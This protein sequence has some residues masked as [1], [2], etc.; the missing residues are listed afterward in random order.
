M[1]AAAGCQAVTFLG[2]VTLKTKAH[3][4]LLAQLPLAASS[5][6]KSGLGGRTAFLGVLVILR[7]ASGYLW[8]QWWLEG[9]LEQDGSVSPLSLVWAIPCVL[10]LGLCAPWEP[11]PLPWNCPH[12]SCVFPCSEGPIRDPWSERLRGSL[13]SS[14]RQAA[15]PV[16]LAPRREVCP[17]AAGL[18]SSGLVGCGGCP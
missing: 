2:H 4:V 14:L 5:T 9:V 8:Q 13:S 11:C 16:R 17:L 7:N 6:A 3:V 15:S 10:F 18:A 1:G 12:Q